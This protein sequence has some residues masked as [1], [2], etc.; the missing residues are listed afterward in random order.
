MPRKKNSLTEQEL[1]A[2]KKLLL[3]RKAILSHDANHLADEALSK[4]KGD[5]A[6]LDISSFADLGSDNFEQELE[7]ELLE[8]HERVLQEINDALI[9]IDIGRFGVCEEC[10]AVIGKARLNAQPYARL[11]LECKKKE[12]ELSGEP[13]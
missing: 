13:Y 8:D 10:D 12:E 7:L 11:C 5:A 1:Q 2:F 9:R 3:A 4:T 6:T